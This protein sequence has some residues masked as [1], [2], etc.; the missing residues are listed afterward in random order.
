MREKSKYIDSSNVKNSGLIR[1]R[2]ATKRERD[3]NSSTTAYCYMFQTISGLVIST[4]PGSQ[5]FQTIQRLVI[6]HYFV[7]SDVSM[8]IPWLVIPPQPR[9]VKCFRDDEVLR[10]CRL[11]S[12]TCENQI[13]YSKNFL[14]WHKSTLLHTTGVLQA[15]LQ[16]EVEWVVRNTNQ[17]TFLILQSGKCGYHGYPVVIASLFLYY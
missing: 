12:C 2:E 9:T 6:F 11:L 7:L 4:Q 16:L 3:C 15:F 5:M 10:N 17:R 8:I 13:L 14:F 1:E